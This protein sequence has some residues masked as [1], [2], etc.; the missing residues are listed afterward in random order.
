MDEDGALINFPTHLTFFTSENSYIAILVK[1][2]CAD[3]IMTMEILFK[4][5][6]VRRVQ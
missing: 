3:D 4:D 1:L 2:F 6:L 5:Y